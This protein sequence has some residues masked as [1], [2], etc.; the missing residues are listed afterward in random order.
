MLQVKHVE[1]LIEKSET[2]RTEDFL[3]DNTIKMN[4]VTQSM[5]HKPSRE[6]IAKSPVYISTIEQGPG[7][8]SLEK[9]ILSESIEL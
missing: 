4:R 7:S 6:E 5:K 9:N 2:S 1:S 8:T 3:D